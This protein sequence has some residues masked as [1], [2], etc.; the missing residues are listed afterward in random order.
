LRKR[1]NSI[2]QAGVSLGLE[3]LRSLCAETG[4][5]SSFERV[6]IAGLH[7][8]LMRHAM[9]VAVCPAPYLKRRDGGGGNGQRI[10]AGC[11]MMWE[12]ILAANQPEEYRQI[13]E[14]LPVEIIRCQCGRKVLGIRQR[15]PGL[16]AR[17]WGIRIPFWRVACHHRPEDYLHSNV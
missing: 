1:V 10:T 15:K 2:L 17:L 9:S 6:N 7:S 13:S 3:T 16:S 4:I 8:M 12:T 5:F 11:F 14:M